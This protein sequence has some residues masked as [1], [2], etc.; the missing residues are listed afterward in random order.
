MQNVFSY[1]L[2][3]DDISTSEKKYT[4]KADTKQLS[5]I[6]DILKVPDIVSLNAILFTEL[7]RSTNLLKIWGNIKLT[8]KLES[9]I[10]LELF[11]KDIKIEFSSQ[12][13]IKMTRKEQKELEEISDNVPEII[14]DGKIDFADIIIEQIALNLDDYPRKDGEVFDFQPEFDVEEKI[15]KNPFDVLKTLK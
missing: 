8:L 5:H 9:V 2:I 1:P 10:S 14:Y 3:V 6:K 12:Y 15:T 4:I 11:E 7:S 13:D